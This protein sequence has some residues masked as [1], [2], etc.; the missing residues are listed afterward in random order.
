[1]L[2]W[3]FD[4]R[5]VLVQNVTSLAARESMGQSNSVID[6]VLLEAGQPGNEVVGENVVYLELGVDWTSFR[7][8]VIRREKERRRGEGGGCSVVA[9]LSNLSTA[10][11][12]L[13]RRS[14]GREKE[15]ELLI[16]EVNDAAGR[17][18][19]PL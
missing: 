12:S 9:C 3:Q 15:A 19:C 1:M 13:A 8:K 14:R 6:S 5:Y 11:A 4:R 17:L 7:S 16:A 18:S 2:L 10:H